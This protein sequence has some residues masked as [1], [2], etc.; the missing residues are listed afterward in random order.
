MKALAEKFD[1]TSFV[2]FHRWNNPPIDSCSAKLAKFK[3]HTSD[4]FSSLTLENDDTNEKNVAPYFPRAS[5]L[6]RSFSSETPVY[7]QRQPRTESL[8]YLPR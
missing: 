4:K 8:N 1:F 6:G 3:C 5:F 2:Y 7:Y